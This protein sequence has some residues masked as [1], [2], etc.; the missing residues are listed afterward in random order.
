MKHQTKMENIIDFTV[1]FIQRSDNI[2]LFI[3]VAESLIA[4]LD[5]WH[6]SLWNTFKYEPASKSTL[7]LLNLKTYSIFRG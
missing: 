4:A 2:H 1:Y 3:S 6:S 7:P 5:S